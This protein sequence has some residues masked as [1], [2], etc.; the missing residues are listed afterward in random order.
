MLLWWS[1]GQ[2][3]G[4]DILMEVTRYAGNSTETRVLVLNDEA[5]VLSHPSKIP[6]A[7]TSDPEI[8][9]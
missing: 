1:V 3:G 7:A 5:H 2:R 4:G 9:K 6:Q 8:G